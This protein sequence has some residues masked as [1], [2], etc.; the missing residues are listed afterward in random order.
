[1]AM[2]ADDWSDV[3]AHLQRRVREQGLSDIDGDIMIDF[4]MSGDP[5]KDTVAYLE[6]L[7]SPVGVRSVDAPART[8]DILRANV[9]TEHG[10]EIEGVDM[11]IEERDRPAYP[12]ERIP[13]DAQN[14]RFRK[15]GVL[16]ELKSLL[17]A[18]QKHRSSRQS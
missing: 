10:G 4:R 6:A 2:T 3:F 7:I 12:V 9:R 11:I 15:E 17:A 1:M 18:V 5:E 16:V 13:L 8:L 14:R